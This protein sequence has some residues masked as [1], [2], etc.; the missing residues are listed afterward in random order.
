MW[1]TVSGSISC[2]KLVISNEIADNPN[3]NASSYSRLDAKA[4]GD[5]NPFNIQ[6]WNGDLSA[7]KNKGGKVCTFFYPKTF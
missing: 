3:W 1:C 6:T 4:A 7:F 5:Q 2:E